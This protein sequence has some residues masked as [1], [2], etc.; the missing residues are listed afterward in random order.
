[1]CFEGLSVAFTSKKRSTASPMTLRASTVSCAWVPGR[2]PCQARVQIATGSPC[3]HLLLKAR[4]H[5]RSRV[6]DEEGVSVAHASSSLAIGAARSRASR[7]LALLARDA[8][9]TSKR[10]GP[11]TSVGLAGRPHHDSAGVLVL[12]LGFPPSHRPRPSHGTGEHSS[13]WHN[14]LLASLRQLLATAIP[15]ITQDQANM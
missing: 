1:M 14:R 11:V 5:G 8:L 2:L 10:S 3:R 15:G 7:P 6:D 4:T 9:A 13:T 12:V